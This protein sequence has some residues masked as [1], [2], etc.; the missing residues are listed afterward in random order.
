MYVMLCWNPRGF[1]LCHT[2]LKIRNSVIPNASYRFQFTFNPSF[3]GPIRVELSFLLIGSSDYL[4][5]PRSKSDSVTVQRT[6]LFSPL[7]LFLVSLSPSRCY[8]WI[9][10][11]YPRKNGRSRMLDA[12]PF[13]RVSM[14][15]II[16]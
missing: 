1:I 10:C 13:S 8:M 9:E 7:F 16:V 14:N 5:I 12:A 15:L 11:A 2:V 4:C 6:L 3:H